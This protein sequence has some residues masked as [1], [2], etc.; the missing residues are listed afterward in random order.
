MGKEQL[1]FFFFRGNVEW[2]QIYEF[3]CSEYSFKTEVSSNSLM[4]VLTFK[5]LSDKPI[6]VNEL[7]QKINASRIKFENWG[8]LESVFKGTEEIKSF[9]DLIIAKGV[10]PIHGK[11]AQIKLYFDNGH[12]SHFKEK[13]DGSIDYKDMA[14]FVSVS[15]DTLLAKYI[16][17]TIGVNGTDIFG[18]VINAHV[19]KSTKFVVGKN[20]TF[21][22]NTE[23]I[24]AA[25]DGIPTEVSGNIKIDPILNIN[26]DLDM[27]VGNIDFS[28]DVYIGGDILDGFKVKAGGDIVVKGTVGASEL[29][30][31]GNICIHG[32]VTS[33]KKG[34]IKCKKLEAKYLNDAYVEASEEVK[35]LKSIMNSL[36]F[37]QGHVIAGIIVAGK[38]IALL[39]VEAQEIGSE[40]G[41][42]TEIELGTDY[43]ALNSFGKKKKK[44]IELDDRLNV[45]IPNFE[46]FIESYDKFYK[47]EVDL[48][49]KIIESFK[50]FQILKKQRLE[51]ES[52]INDCELNFRIHRD[53]KK[54]FIITKMVYEG[55]VVE[56][57]F[58]H[59]KL[60]QTFKGPVSIRENR[61]FHTFDIGTV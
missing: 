12:A 43:K 52:Q 5:K 46:P 34:F 60:K 24:Y 32:G 6:S 10:A 18:E 39:G 3:K 37:T 20:T 31:A 47:L 33:R 27:S 25:I 30:S 45:L 61:K 29:I 35:V 1:S 58:A 4:A 26:K 57:R 54:K 42:V 55:L 17:E 13:E 11:D 49:S 44:R 48:K 41:V 7:L 53:I 9:S 8:E 36:V 50:E 59:L 15:K 23:T 28:G 40:Q 19:G 21:K 14:K 22:E 51:M 56:S 2:R 16:K 38:T